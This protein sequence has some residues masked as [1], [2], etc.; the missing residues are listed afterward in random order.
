MPKLGQRLTGL[1]ARGKSRP[2]VWLS[3]PDEYRH[4]MYHPWM[5]AKAQAKFRGEGFEL[6]FEQFFELWNGR[7]HERGRGIDDLCITRINPDKAWKK[8]NVHVITRREHLNIQG[9]WQFHKRGGK[10]KSK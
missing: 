10:R 7:W 3:G 6:T 5:L 2:H 4:S 8:S 9:I 1:H